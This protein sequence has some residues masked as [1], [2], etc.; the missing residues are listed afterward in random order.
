MNFFLKEEKSKIVLFSSLSSWLFFLDLCIML[1][2]S[3]GLL[4]KFVD[5]KLMEGWFCASGPGFWRP[6]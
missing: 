1:V 3:R 2:A 5:F 4:E 6:R